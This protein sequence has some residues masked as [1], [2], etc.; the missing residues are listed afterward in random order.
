M[1]A[2][3]LGPRV[4]TRLSV[5]EHLRFQKT[6]DLMNLTQGQLARD[7]I[8]FYLDALQSEGNKARDVALETRISSLEE[9]LTTLMS[10]A[11]VDIGIV[12]SLL[13]KRMDRETRDEDI[14]IA[15]EK[16]TQ[17]LKRKIEKSKLSSEQLEQSA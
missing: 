7:A 15:H 10:H 17:R 16:S 14:K 11:N 12:I 13:Y 3:G 8:C 2:T 9:T 1:S 4:Q 5:K 6:M